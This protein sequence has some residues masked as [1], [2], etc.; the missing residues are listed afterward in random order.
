MRRPSWLIWTT[1]Q[2]QSAPAEILD[3]VAPTTSRRMARTAQRDNR[4][5]RALRSILHRRGLRF[6]VHR[7]ILER[8]RRTVDIAFAGARV[9]V[10]IDGCFWHDCPI[11]GTS[12]INNAAWW[13][14]KIDAN[15]AR[16]RD[17]DTR[18]LASGWTVVRIWEHEDLSHAA[19][20]I[21]A[22]VRVS[23]HKA[24]TRS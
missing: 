5:E 1:M 21:E 15:V 2:R 23:R 19:D 16:D 22:L 24:K 14:A 3:P 13:R 11:H 8:T 18:L 10:F 17:T 4:N 6:R 7:R 12:P 9:A 20:R